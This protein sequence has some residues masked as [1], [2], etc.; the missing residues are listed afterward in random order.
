[1]DLTEIK[2][3]PPAK[4]ILVVQEIWDSIAE[5]E[6]IELTDETKAEL[7]RRLERHRSGEAEYFTLKDVKSMLDEKRR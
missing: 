6:E 4:R 7:D 2:K 1:M 5:K 3:M